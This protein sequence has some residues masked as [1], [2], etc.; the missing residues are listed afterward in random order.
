MPRIS[1]RTRVARR[2]W[3]LAGAALSL[4]ALLPAEALARAGSG[5][6]SFGRSVG[7][8]GGM[9]YRGRGGYGGPHVF[10]F[11]GG[12]GG[13]LLLLLILVVVLLFAA[14][15]ISRRRRRQRW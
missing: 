5:S 1:P 9:G 15:R 6:S 3:L 8:G 7:R 12:G 10:F 2:L 11:G 13:G 14:S 4:C